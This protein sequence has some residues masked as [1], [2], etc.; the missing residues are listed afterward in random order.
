MNKRAAFLLL[1]IFTPPLFLMAEDAASG[2]KPA[3]HLAPKSKKR[4]KGKRNITFSYTNEDIVNVINYLAAEKGVNIMLPLGANAITGKLTLNIEEKLTLDE[5][6]DKITTILDVAGYSIFPRNDMY[7]VVKNSPNT[8]KE[9]LPIYIGTAPHD[10]PDGDERIR[11]LYY[12]SNIKV[13]ETGA[14]TNELGAVL[15]EILPDSAIYRFD[16]LTNGMLVIDKADNIRAAM[17]IIVE[18]DKVGFKETLDILRLR[19]TNAVIIADLFN[20]NILKS[21]TDERFSFGPRRAGES[22]FFSKAAKIIPDERTNSLIVLG[23]PQ[24]IDRIKEFIYQYIDVELESGKSILH[25]VQLQYL[26]ASSFAD[27]LT[28]IVQGNRPAGTEQ[29][30][31]IGA[32]GGPE[33]YFDGVIIKSDKPSEGGGTGKYFGGNKLVIAARNED[34]ERI[35]ELIEKLD[36]P[37]PT[38]IIEVLVADLTLNDEMLF[39]TQ[40]R[41]P[42]DIPFPAG[43]NF[44]SAQLNRLISPN[45]APAGL[46]TDLLKKDFGGTKSLAGQASP[47]STVLSIN[48]TK[49]SGIWAVLQILRDYGNTKILSNPHIIAINNQQ[50]SVDI[51]NTRLVAGAASGSAGGSTTA[52]NEEIPAELKV[53][54]TPRISSADMVNL[55]VDIKVNEFTNPTSETDATRTE[56]RIITNANIKSHGVLALGGLIKD[57]TAHITRETP[58]LGKIPIL[59]WLFK[60]RDTTLERNNLTVFISPTIVQPRLRGG[61]GDYTRD[62]LKV[63]KKYVNEGTTFDTL[64]DPVT[65]WFFKTESDAGQ[66]LDS[67]LAKDESDQAQERA[68]LAELSALDEQ[69]KKT[70]KKVAEKKTKR[71]KKSQRTAHKE[72]ES[73][74]QPEDKPVEKIAV[75]QKT[76]E[77]GSII[78][79]AQEKEVNKEKPDVIV[80]P[81]KGPKKEQTKIELTDAKEVSKQ[82]PATAV[83]HA[84][85]SKFGKLAQLFNDSDNPFSMSKMVTS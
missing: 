50:A 34:W 55:Q 58:L 24:A 45:P 35:R 12:L 65:R 17:K 38:V 51:A 72:K 36:T 9:P 76:T 59:G 25:I 20:K 27:V 70:E 13:P 49:G 6:W 22:S 14:E 33:R 64:R 4:K 48:D 78:T 68:F 53:L 61:V 43:L 57:S 39:G 32:S 63:A 84:P 3:S 42:L 23:K 81:K 5:A 18:L 28:R 44:Q 16:S 21:S 69:G 31:I 26:D 73:T 1:L 7:M 56:R 47:G 52:A 77:L 80:E 8:S 79:S 40:L 15:K 10:L 46:A 82:K 83:A 62:Y 66:V 71:E 37:Q 2:Q 54:I 60:S 41:N 85:K 67:F 19:H 75:V 30:R 11:Y 29:S 74:V